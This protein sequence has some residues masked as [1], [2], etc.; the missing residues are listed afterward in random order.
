MYVQR[1]HKITLKG[2]YAKL[3]PLGIKNL[4]ALNHKIGTLKDFLLIDSFQ[5][6][7]DL[8]F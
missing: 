7:F 5:G 3:E 8:L 6:L 1:V 4:Q 2:G